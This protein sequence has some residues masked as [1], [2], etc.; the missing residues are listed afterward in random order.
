MLAQLERCEFA[1][2]CLTLNKQ[3]LPWL[4]DNATYEPHVCNSQIAA[5]PLLY[6]R[7][8]PTMNKDNAEKD[9]YTY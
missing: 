2:S 1:H 3:P 8:S 4:V 5:G 7:S 6:S 9:K